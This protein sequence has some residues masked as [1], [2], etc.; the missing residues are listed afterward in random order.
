LGAFKEGKAMKHTDTVIIGGGQAGLAMSRCL[1]E[2]RVS[3]VVL[4]RGRV[5]ERWR[6][7]RWDSLRLLTPN[8]HS[9]LP[10]W[11]Y[12]GKDPDGYMTMP[13]LI[14]HLERYARSFDA[15]VRTGTTVQAVERVA[16][17]RYRV[18]TDRG[19]W[20]ATN[21][22]IATGHC[23]VPW[24]PALGSGLPDDVFQIVPSKYRNPGQLPA[25]NVLVV[26]ASTSGAQLAEELAGA[27]RK[28][29]LAVGRHTR[30][31]RRYRGKDILW[32]IDT[33]GGFMSPADPAEEA[34]S[35][36]PQLVGS[37]DNRSLDIGLLQERGV[38]LAGKL[39]AAEGNRVRF[40][41]NLAE[42]VKVADDQLA[43]TLAKI[44]DF[45]TTMGLDDKVGPPEGVRQ[46][47]LQPAL[48]EI[49]LRAENITTVLWA[50]GYRRRYPWLKVPVLDERGEICHAGG[51]TAEPGLYVLGLRFQR[52]KNSNFI[53]GVGNDAAELTRHLVERLRERAA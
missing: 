30:L 19:V 13:E 44:D 48:T 32:W 24:V 18:T 12:E 4:E 40:D 7:E 41:D 5:G 25:G 34:E 1:T 15:P 11:H 43:A 29:T 36:A 52:R 23:D 46:I 10:H 22:V 26:G 2:R 37:P 47:R 16:P 17:E 50:T 20:T 51:V 21:V 38:R 35:P 27:G 14:D 9:R 53:D 45:A 3:H 31:P 6:S 49:D 39:I 28:V 42:I 33:M 8:W